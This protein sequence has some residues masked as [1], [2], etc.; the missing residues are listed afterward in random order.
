MV[1]ILL[2]LEYLVTAPGRLIV[3]FRWA[4]PG[5][6]IHHDN[7]ARD[8]R[9]LHWMASVGFYIWLGVMVDQGIQ[10]GVF[11]T[12]WADMRTAFASR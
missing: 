1:E 2:A 4:M 7:E 10:S 11:V 8:D 6:W 5:N 12:A 3:W 9:V